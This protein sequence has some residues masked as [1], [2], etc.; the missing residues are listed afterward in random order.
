M[1]SEGSGNWR[2]VN[3]TLANGLALVTSDASNVTQLV[4]ST[5]PAGEAITIGTNTSLVFIE[6][7]PTIANSLIATNL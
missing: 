1:R 3:Y 7:I 5:I 2:C 6:D 4:D